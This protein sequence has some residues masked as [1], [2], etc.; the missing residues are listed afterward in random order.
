M[1]IAE[2]QQVAAGTRHGYVELAVDDA[3]LKANSTKVL[4]PGYLTL[5]KP[6]KKKDDEN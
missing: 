3:S 1:R 2:Q 5:I 6:E 4:Y